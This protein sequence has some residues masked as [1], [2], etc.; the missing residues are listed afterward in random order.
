MNH[1]FLG[2]R[3]NGKWERCRRK[4]KGVNKRGR[5]KEKIKEKGDRGN[6]KM[7]NDKEKVVKGE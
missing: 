2:K 3:G 1:Y 6:G 5:R 7:Q 4:I